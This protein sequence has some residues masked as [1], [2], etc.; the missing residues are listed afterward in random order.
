MTLQTR[1]IVRNIAHVI[2]VVPSTATM[3][4]VVGVQVMLMEEVFA[5]P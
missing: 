1:I 4:I 2:A 3:G 5:S